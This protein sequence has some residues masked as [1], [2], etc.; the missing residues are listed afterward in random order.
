MEPLMDRHVETIIAHR[1]AAMVLL[2][3]AAASADS[4]VVDAAARGSKAAGGRLMKPSRTG[5]RRLAIVDPGR[6][7]AL[8]A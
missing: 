1:R 3:Q 6:S 8:N 7:D 2:K 5:F 4:R